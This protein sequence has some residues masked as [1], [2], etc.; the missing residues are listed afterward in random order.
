MS[1][2][3]EKLRILLANR[4]WTQTK[5]AKQLFAVLGYGFAAVG[6]GFV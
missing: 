4:E 1:K 2:L 5:L 6:D 3:N